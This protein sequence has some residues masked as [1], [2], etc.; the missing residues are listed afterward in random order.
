MSIKTDHHV[1]HVCDRASVMSS[2]EESFLKSHCEA[3]SVV[4]RAVDVLAVPDS[5]N[6]QLI[7]NWAK[8]GADWPK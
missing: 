1:F 3:H 4:A 5:A 8:S 6:S 2:V 7:E